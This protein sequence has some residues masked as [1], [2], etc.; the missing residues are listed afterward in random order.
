L[1]F[2]SARASAQLMIGSSSI[3]CSTS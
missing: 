2:S 3:V 1:R